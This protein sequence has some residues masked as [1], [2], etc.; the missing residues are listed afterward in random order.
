VGLD[1]AGVRGERVVSV[2]SC[3][4]AADFIALTVA[5]AVDA[6]FKA[7]AAHPEAVPSAPAEA[8]AVESTAEPSSA[9]TSPQNSPPRDPRLPTQSSDSRLQDG[10]KEAVMVVLRR[11]LLQVNVSAQTR[12]VSSPISGKR[13]QAVLL[14][15]GLPALLLAG[16]TLIGALAFLAGAFETGEVLTSQTSPDGKWTLVVKH[17]GPSFSPRGPSTVTLWGRHAGDDDE[18]RLATFSV[19]NDG[20]TLYDGSCTISWL[21]RGPTVAQVVCQGEEQTDDVWL[22]NLHAKEAWRLAGD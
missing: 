17:E 21:P 12:P 8:L 3:T 10:P 2:G 22:V 5:L 11:W 9:R 19:N 14:T 15:L 16:A 18:S 4:E 7:P 13:G 6:D 20:A 1:V